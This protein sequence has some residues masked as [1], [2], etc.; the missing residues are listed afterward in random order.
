[1]ERETDRQRKGIKRVKKDRQRQTDKDRRR[2][3]DVVTNWQADKTR[4]AAQKKK[5]SKKKWSKLTNGH[6]K[7]FVH[8]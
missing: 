2:S 7:N 1:M 3:K 4:R 5:I 8:C 6:F